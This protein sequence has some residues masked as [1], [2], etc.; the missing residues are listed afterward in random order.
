MS[1]VL[2]FTVVTLY[3][4]T[5]ILVG[6]FLSSLTARWT[7]L[8]TNIDGISDNTP[9][10][11]LVYFAIGV[12]FFGLFSIPLYILKLPSYVFTLFYICVVA[13]S[14]FYYLHKLFT[15]KLKV[16]I[17]TFRGLD[18]RIVVIAL[19][20]AGLLVF[21]Y[22]VSGVFGTMFAGGVDAYV[23]LA[24]IVGILSYGF[25]MD[26]GFYRGVIE[27]RY[28]INVI[29]ALYIP[30]AHLSHF[31]PAVSWNLSLGFFRLLQW[32]SLIG[33]AYFIARYWLNTTKIRAGLVGLVVLLFNIA[34][35]PL[36][37]NVALYPTKIVTL[38]VTVFIVGLSTCSRYP[39]TGY[40][41][42]L[43]SSA[44]L[45]LTHPTYALM[46]ALFLMIYLILSVVVG[47]LRRRRIK[48]VVFL[49]HVLSLMILLAS[50]LFT[51]SFPSYI[52]HDLFNVG[53]VS[54]MSLL[55]VEIIQPLYPRDFNQLLLAAISFVGGLYILLKLK[56]A[57]RIDQIVLVL[58]LYSFYYLLVCNP[59]FMSLVNERVPLWFLERFSTMNI[60]QTITLPLGVYVLFILCGVIA[61]SWPAVLRR[62][63]F[64]AS[65]VAMLVFLMLNTAESYDKFND[66]TLG[67]NFG[68]Y[69]LIQ[70]ISKELLGVIPQGSLVV[71]P[72]N[73][74]YHLPSAIPVRVLAID[75]THAT[76]SAASKQR[77]ACVDKLFDENINWS[78]LAII[79]A[80][81]I[82]LP[83]SYK[84]YASSQYVAINNQ[85]DKFKL[86]TESSDYVVYRIEKSKYADQLLTGSADNPCYKYQL[87]ERGL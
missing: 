50:P 35:P 54:T 81:Y 6:A 1:F 23:H 15:K 66:T 14:S 13:A 28:H 78:D 41:L 38:W 18:P 59:I 61:K 74:S 39:R 29:H 7:R 43:L 19:I 73:D 25:S 64:V 34:L 58:L 84:V 79:K 12:V 48:Y 46:C 9:L 69:E 30:L 32:F 26:D 70:R 77:L 45:S 2:D 31:T 16:K 27:S 47:M 24:K 67:I 65:S 76:P 4:S 5:L 62:A 51:A 17:F 10:M 55:N 8:R 40:S 37:M 57:G 56:H 36:F 11:V 60:L 80:D 52:T 68:H 83:L 86:I 42:I 33:L 85:I 71:A 20:V 44:L 3:W 63:M 21:D 22:I 87:I 82:I 49:P 53:T 75:S 72:L